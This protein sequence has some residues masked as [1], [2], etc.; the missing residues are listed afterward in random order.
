MFL[1]MVGGHGQCFWGWLVVMD[2]ILGDDYGPYLWI[3]CGGHIF[4]IMIFYNLFT[5]LVT[6][7]D[8]SLVTLR[9]SMLCFVFVFST[10][11]F[12]YTS[13]STYYFVP[14]YSLAHY[15]LTLVSLPIISS[16]SIL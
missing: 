11:L 3:F 1:G 5:L 13:F 8:I 10:S 4:W 9:F 7:G 16:L 6:R 15:F 14:L 12:S 2:N